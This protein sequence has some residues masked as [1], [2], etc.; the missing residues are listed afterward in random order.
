MRKFLS[1]FLVI[2]LIS[3]VSCENVE[4]PSESSL[5]ENASQDFY[6]QLESQLPEIDQSFAQEERDFVI[7]TDNMGTFTQDETAAASKNLAISD[8]NFFL[9]MKY[10]ANIIVEEYTAE[11]IE[12]ILSE[13]LEKGTNPCDMICLSAEDT[14]E[15]YK[16]GLL[17]NINALPDFNLENG[18]FDFDLAKT[19]ATNNS[20]YML[21]D[22]CAYMYD[23]TY[24]IYYNRD[25]VKAPEGGEDV[26]TLALQGKWT[27]DAFYDYCRSSAPNSFSSS[28]SNLKT[29]VFGYAFIAEPADF[30][31]AM[32]VSTNQQIVANTYKNPVEITLDRETVTPTADFLRSIYNVRGRYPLS[33]S[34][35]RKAFE[36][37]RIAFYCDELGY[38]YNLRDGTSKGTE[39]GVLPMPKMN[40]EQ[41]EYRCLL[42]NNAHVISIPKTL[43]TADDKTKTYASAMISATCAAGSATIK[44]AYLNTM[45]GMFL[46][47]NNETVII[48]TIVDSATFDFAVTF[49]SAIS[50]IRTP[51][52]KP[53]ANYIVDGLSLSTPGRQDFKEYCDKNFQ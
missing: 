19:L 13:A 42:N 39:Y 35:A 31:E 23:N 2:L 28:G 43:E 26:E 53:V 5:S 37:G 46:T 8:R 10:G 25:L 27:W 32:W 12:Y 20:L 7:F 14:L 47:T 22:P 45:L 3:L 18:F 36:E 33:G 29:D 30:A 41:S 49:G 15:L 24:V 16:K 40:E 11:E 6:E 38:L 52:M 21:A 51:T 48:K 44:D 1:L 50:E 9:E 17:G 4:Y 34:D